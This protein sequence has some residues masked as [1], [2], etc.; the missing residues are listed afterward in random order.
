LL[1][2]KIVQ[3]RYQERLGTCNLIKLLTQI[4][5]WVKM[6]LEYIDVTPRMPIFKILRPNIKIEDKALNMLSRYRSGVGTL[7]HLAKVSRPDIRNVM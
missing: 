3:Q 4:K 7:L 1:N 2:W 5:S 6:S